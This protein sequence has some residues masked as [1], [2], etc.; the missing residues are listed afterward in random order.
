M[1]QSG[2][3][4]YFRLFS[5]VGSTDDTRR[6]GGHILHMRVPFRTHGRYYDPVRVLSSHH[7]LHGHGSRA[8]K[9][10]RP[11]SRTWEDSGQVGWRKPSFRLYCAQYHT[12]QHSTCTHAST[13]YA[14]STT[15]TAHNAQHA[16]NTP[17]TRRTQTRARQ[18]PHARTRARQAPHAARAGT[19][20]RRHAGTQA[21][22]HAGTQA[23][24]HASTQEETRG[25]GGAPARCLTT[26]KT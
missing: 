21:R 22:R 11:H 7:T 6:A 10:P 26:M 17:P 19:Q 24:R 25:V 14:C 12:T 9:W 15:P 4:V 2:C 8:H 1:Q 5:A 13:Q 16:A 3:T 18:T 20:A 23:R